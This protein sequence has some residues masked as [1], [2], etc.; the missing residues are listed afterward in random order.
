[1][2]TF[3][4]KK[5]DKADLNLVG[6]V[7]IITDLINDKHYIGIKNF[8]SKKQYQLNNKK[9]SKFV[10]SDWQD[11]Y[12]SSEQLKEQVKLK[13]KENFKRQIIYL[14]K[15]KSAM[16]YYECLLQMN[17]NVLAS[18]KFYNSIINI[19]INRRCYKADW[20]ADKDEILLKELEKL[21]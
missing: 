1:M 18:D 15:T 2:W 6:F 13:G 7:Y 21:K 14:C 4:N 19:R 10:E 12:G 20:I 9:K 16:N 3:K 11:Y 5:Y 17:L 8:K